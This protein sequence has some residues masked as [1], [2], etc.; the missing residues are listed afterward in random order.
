M[1]TPRIYLE[2]TV[3]NYY[4]DQE[5]DAQPY[6]LTLFAEIKAGKY[7][8]YTSEYVTNELNKAPSEKQGK[9]LNLMTEVVDL[10][11]GYKKVGIFSPMEVVEH[12]ENS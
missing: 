11:E 10:R 3:F 8:P 1:I 6:T 2:T 4:F 12:D 5:R 9:M 7:E